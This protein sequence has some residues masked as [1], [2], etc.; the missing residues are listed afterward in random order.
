[1]WMSVP[2]SRLRSLVALRAIRR[3]FRSSRRP[4]LITWGSLSPKTNSASS[5]RA[6]ISTQLRLLNTRTPPPELPARYTT[7][8]WVPPTPANGTA[9]AGLPHTLARVGGQCHGG[10]SLGR[11]PPVLHRDHRARV[12][13]AYQRDQRRRLAH[14]P[15]VEPAH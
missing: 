4:S 11:P 10:G 8:W 9:T 5:S 13:L 14:R 2:N 1:S 6:A 7:T 15:S 3:R 12:V